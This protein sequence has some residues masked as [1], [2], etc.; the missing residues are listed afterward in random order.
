MF[1]RER[2]NQPQNRSNSLIKS[3]GVYTHQIEK[4]MKFQPGNNSDADSHRREASLR[5]RNE[6]LKA[7]CF[8][9]MF[10]ITCCIV[11]GALALLG[12]LLLYAPD[13]RLVWKMVAS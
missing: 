10:F 5:E 8:L 3:K 11:F 4:N 2:Q 6:M 12:A 9:M 13:V 1:R 7:A